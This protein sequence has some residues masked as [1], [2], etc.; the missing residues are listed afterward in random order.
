MGKSSVLPQGHVLSVDWK[1]QRINPAYKSAKDRRD[2][3]YTNDKL[4]NGEVKCKCVG[5][6]P[7]DITGHAL[8]S[9]TTCDNSVANQY[10]SGRLF[11]RCCWTSRMEQSANPAARVRHYTR[12][13]ST[14]TQNA[15][16]WSL[17]MLSGSVFFFVRCVQICLLMVLNRRSISFAFQLHDKTA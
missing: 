13:I 10:T 7:T 2:R 1:P 4:S 6:K 16:V 3:D 12:T 5:K 17:T 9:M 8:T 14:S 11:I 15:S